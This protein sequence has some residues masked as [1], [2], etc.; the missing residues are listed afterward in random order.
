MLCPSC[1]NDLIKGANFCPTCGADQT[2][3]LEPTPPRVEK[4]PASTVILSEMLANVEVVPY[5]GQYVRVTIEGDEATKQAA[6]L[7][8]ANDTI[9]ISAPLPF[10]TGRGTGR[11]SGGF[12][13]GSVN[14]VSNFIGG[15]S[16]SGT[17]WVNGQLYV[18]NQAVD[19]S[20][21]I[22]VV[23]EV[24][25]GTTVKVGKLIGLANIGDIN[26]DLEVKISGITEIQAGMIKNLQVKISGSGNVIVQQ[27]NGIVSARI[28]G[29]GN[30]AINSGYSTSFTTTV[31]GS[32]NVNFG[33][34][35]EKA[36][37]SV[38]GSGDIYLGECLTTPIKS[39][40]GSGH[41]S[42]GKAP[43]AQKGSEKFSNW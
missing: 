30:I 37:M 29:S 8:L 26:G 40:S 21:T 16:S 18:D 38:S 12:L 6:V 34:V 41:I 10:K 3:F 31:S 19:M 42:V 14:V 24:P 25:I 33:G 35:A 2:K 11:H 4:H 13:A 28:N 15:T 39:K 36:D 32:G 7:E 22:Q 27:V 1:R 20:R 5:D 17:S 9:M 23:V 43:Q